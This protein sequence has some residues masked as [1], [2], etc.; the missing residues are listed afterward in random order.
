MWC[1]QNQKGQNFLAVALLLKTKL[2]QKEKNISFH[3]QEK[4]Y[5]QK[6]LSTARQKSTA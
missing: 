3:N 1:N 5:G 6:N 2:I 4:S